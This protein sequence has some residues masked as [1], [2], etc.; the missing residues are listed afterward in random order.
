MTW[1]TPRRL[2]WALRLHG[3]D[4]AAWPVDQRA[5]ALSLM[6]RCKQARRIMADALAQEDLL[7]AD[8]YLTDPPPGDAALLASMQ[9]RLL[10]RLVARSPAVP[11]IRWGAFVACALAGLYLGTADF[12][13]ERPDLFAAVQVIAIDAAL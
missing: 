7:P 3:T 12:D 4:L 9:C 13:A 8:S 6:R 5:A 11:A 1:M 10:R 2:D